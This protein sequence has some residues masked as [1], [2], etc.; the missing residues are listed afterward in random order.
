MADAPDFTP[1][2]NHFRK[3]HQ[4]KF[5]FF[6]ILCANFRIQPVAVLAYQSFLTQNQFPR[7][8]DGKTFQNQQGKMLPIIMHRLTPALIMIFYCILVAFNP[9]T[10]VNVIHVVCFPS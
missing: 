8:T 10:P 1:V 4:K 2:V 9:G 7:Q 3:P 6:A 5:L